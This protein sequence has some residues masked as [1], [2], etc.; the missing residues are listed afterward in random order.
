[1]E[2]CLVQRYLGL[3]ER[4]TTFG[5]KDRRTGTEVNACVAYLTA[6]NICLNIIHSRFDGTSVP[7]LREYEHLAINPYKSQQV[8]PMRHPESQQN[9]DSDA[10]SLIS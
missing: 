10:I 5:R 4:F 1:M 3:D 2:V 7:S 6:I 8:T 9:L